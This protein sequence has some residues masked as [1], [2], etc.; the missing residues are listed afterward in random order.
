VVEY[1]KGEWAYA[2][3]CIRLTAKQAFSAATAP[4]REPV[5]DLPA[6]CGRVYIAQEH[7]PSCL[8]YER[9]V[10]GD[11]FSAKERILHAE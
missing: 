9:T 1:I 6:P 11:A 4:I 10:G 3:I 2:S 7:P 8:I 5:I